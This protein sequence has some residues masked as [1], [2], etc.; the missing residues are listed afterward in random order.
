MILSIR[1]AA[2]AGGIF[3]LSAC[4]GGDGSLFNSRDAEAA[5]AYDQLFITYPDATDPA[6]LPSNVV[7]YAG[8]AAGYVDA[9]IRGGDN[10]VARTELTV[11]FGTDDANG[12]IYD[13]VGQFGT[14]SGEIT[15]L[16]GDVDYTDASFSVEVDGSVT[17]EG[18]EFFTYG[19]LEG[20]FGGP[21]AEAFVADGA[22]DVTDIEGSST[23]IGDGGFL[24]FGEQVS[25]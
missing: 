13:F 4:G 19:T 7:N 18:T 23:F 16:N 17:L 20:A 15:L 1:G 5:A 8:Y 10:L 11:D 21:N 6:D 25:P 12:R 24:I 3:A 14:A 22:V 2:C 9:G